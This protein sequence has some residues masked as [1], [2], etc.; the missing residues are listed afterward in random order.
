MAQTGLESE[1]KLSSLV[2]A[3]HQTIYTRESFSRKKEFGSSLQRL[4][5]RLA[6]GRCVLGAIDYHYHYPTLLLQR[7]LRR[8]LFA[9]TITP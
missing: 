9:L 8:Y 6:Q 3:Y 7:T 4:S 1:F 5:V 2:R